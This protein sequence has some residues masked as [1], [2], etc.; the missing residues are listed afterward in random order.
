MRTPAL[1]ASPTILATFAIAP[2][3][4]V[5]FDTI[6]QAA[7]EFRFS[8]KKVYFIMIV[9]I[10]FGCFVYTANNTIA[11]AAANWP[12]LIIEASSTPWLLLAAAEALLGTPGKV[13]VGIAVSCAVLSGIMGFYLASSRL[14]LLHE[15]RRLP[16]RRVRRD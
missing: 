6:P 9:A 3:A 1:P 5:G 12:E 4:F 7:E 8:H 14:P 2:W 10:A 11:A 15:P 16:P 13:L